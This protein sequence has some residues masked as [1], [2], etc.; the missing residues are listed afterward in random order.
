MYY[1]TEFEAALNR[2]L[3]MRVHLFCWSVQTYPS[4]TAPGKTTASQEALLVRTTYQDYN[5]HLSQKLK[6]IDKRTRS[7]IIKI[8]HF[9]VLDLISMPID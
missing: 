3:G 4:M 8:H 5:H 9:S 6:S 7:T 1:K 2:L